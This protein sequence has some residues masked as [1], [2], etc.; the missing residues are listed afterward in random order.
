MCLDHLN[1]SNPTELHRLESKHHT[2]MQ[3]PM[4]GDCAL[5]LAKPAPSHPVKHAPRRGGCR[6]CSELTEFAVLARC[7]AP[8]YLPG[9][10]SKWEM[11]PCVPDP[12]VANAAGRAVCWAVSAKD[13]RWQQGA[14]TQELQ[15]GRTA[16]KGPLKP[17]GLILH[18]LVSCL[19]VTPVE[20]RDQ[21]ELA[22]GTDTPGEGGLAAASLFQAPLGEERTALCPVPTHPRAVLAWNSPS[23][24][25]RCPR[26]DQPG[27]F[28]LPRP[29]P[30]EQQRGDSG[31][32]SRPVR[33]SLS[34]PPLPPG[35]RSRDEPPLSTSSPPR[36]AMPARVPV[37]PVA[38]PSPA[39]PG[40]GRA[41]QSAG[42]GSAGA[43]AEP[44][45][46][47]EQREGRAGGG[48]GEA[49]TG[50]DT[51]SAEPTRRPG[52]G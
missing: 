32:W 52:R 14:S 23:Q 17:C 9:Q 38:I 42:R 2:H 36:A 15:T 47:G 27:L 33:R 50:T 44:G 31:C 5:L 4:Q 46:R 16:L 22:G 40:C 49:G 26:A 35:S 18:P 6:S 37:C 13:K 20:C 28:P 41:G 30:S 19:C 10:E 7:S 3:R 43:G 48:S 11:R 29:V 39:A 45:H 1:R 12:A 8:K 51:Y 34:A 21:S 25:D 24:R